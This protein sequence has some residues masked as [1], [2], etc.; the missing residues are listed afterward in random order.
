M[1]KYMIYAGGGQGYQVYDA[2]PDFP[3][4][5][6]TKIINLYE[7][8]RFDGFAYSEADRRCYRFLPVGEQYVFSVIYKDCTCTAQGES[9]RI[10]ATVNWLLTPQEADLF[11]GR[12]MIETIES[13][14]STSDECLQEAGY[15]F[16]PTPLPLVF[17][18]VLPSK[19]EQ[20]ALSAGAYFAAAASQREDKALSAQVFVGCSREQGLFAS[21]FWLLFTYPEKM[22]KT[23]SFYLGATRVSETYGVAV[24]LFYNDILEGIQGAGDYSGAMAVQRIVLLQGEFTPTSFLP[25]VI[26]RLEPMSE[27]K[28]K[29][30]YDVFRESEN[31]ANFWAYMSALNE[32]DSKRLSGAALVDTI[33]EATFRSALE[34]DCFSKEE[35]RKIYDEQEQ[36]FVAEET[37]TALTDKL[38]LPANT[39]SLHGATLV[40][41]MG[42]A[43]F[44]DALE[45]DCFSLKELQLIYDEQE[46]LDVS[47][48]TW[49]TIMN[50]LGLPENL[51]NLHGAALVEAM[52]EQAFQA[53]M[54][55]GVFS[56][57][58]LRQVYDDYK[59]L[60]V[61][62]ETWQLLAARL[63]LPEKPYKRYCAGNKKKKAAGQKNGW[64]SKAFSAL[65]QIKWPSV[66]RSRLV[67]VAGYA[68][69]FLINI[70]FAVAFILEM[71]WIGIAVIARLAAPYASMA[72]LAQLLLTSLF[73]T[74]WS[75]G[76]ASH[77]RSLRK[78]REEQ[79]ATE[80]PQ[81][82]TVIPQEEER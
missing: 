10:F 2:H 75:C 20:M 62:W 58:T 19:N 43:A 8:Q 57:R 49:A 52:G 33:G 30:L 79:S 29:K 26:E 22:R 76:V 12:D 38:D 50:K 18:K 39:R 46:R 15:V 3:A 56:N 53:A 31:A 59:Q 69:R 68:A 44:C 17:E 34:N 54:E 74:L 78:R 42:E 41:V 80:T 4:E 61:D 7:G 60:T 65:G 5:Y 66:N 24:A 14:L 81:E 47:D 48:H 55:K 64:I 28:D 11:F 27:E 82:N 72:Y 45:K 51:R 77:I 9:R 6:K 37:W 70:A 40:T 21:L 13:C 67:C 16:E 73:F 1:L 32:E 36:L 71:Y 25:S 35:L 23:V 63:E